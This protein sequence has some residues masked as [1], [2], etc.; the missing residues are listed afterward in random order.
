[1]KVNPTKTAAIILVFA[2]GSGC[3]YW[4]RYFQY[5]DSYNV[6]GLMTYNLAP[7]Y[8][9][10]FTEEALSNLPIK[11]YE[12]GFGKVDAMVQQLVSK[13]PAP[14]PTNDWTAPL[15]DIYATPE[16]YTAKTR[17]TEIGPRI[18]PALV[19]HLRDDRYCY[20][21]YISAWANISVGDTVLEILSAG[22]YWPCPYKGRATPSGGVLGLTFREYLNSRDLEKWAEWAKDRT[23]QEIQRSFLQWCL[24]REREV[25]FVDESQ[26]NEIERRYE[27]AFAKTDPR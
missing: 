25:G 4:L 1:M 26:R 6:S 18:F 5:P 2:T 19:K 15:L 20:S 23:R 24:D 16:V 27:D 3:G 13:R 9:I 22:T 17:L 21:A 10:S 11:T 8:D 14:Y 12:S 7:S